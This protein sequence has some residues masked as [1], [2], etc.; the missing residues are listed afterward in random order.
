MANRKHSEFYR[1]V[2]DLIRKLRERP[3]HGMTQEELGRRVGLSRVSIV[4]V[5]KGRQHLAVH[6]LYMFAKAL[7][8]KP[9]ALLPR[10]TEG[11][12]WIVDKL[13]AGTDKNIAQWAKKL[14]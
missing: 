8:V 9:E 7:S 13:P 5:E 1:D 14:A 6:Q 10:P 12:G 4:N 2:G 3:D 11:S